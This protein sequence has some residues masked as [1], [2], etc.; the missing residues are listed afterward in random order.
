VTPAA[1]KFS[2]SRLPPWAQ[3]KIA[4]DEPPASGGKEG[5]NATGNTKKALQSRWA[6][7]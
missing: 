4:R 6:E 1:F 7:V 2:V 3:A 5:A